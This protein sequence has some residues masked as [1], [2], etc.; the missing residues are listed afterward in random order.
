MD[1]A[2]P[3]ACGKRSESGWASLLDGIVGRSDEERDSAQWGNIECSC[4]RYLLSYY[5]CEL[6]T[7]P[8]LRGILS[9]AF[10][11]VAPLAPSPALPKEH[12]SHQFQSIQAWCVGIK[13]PERSSSR[14][15]ET[16]PIT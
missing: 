2:G 13:R 14:S 1:C 6:L 3:V 12:A 9:I 4:C 15:S 16:K 11:R 7:M 5:Y 8:S 10:L